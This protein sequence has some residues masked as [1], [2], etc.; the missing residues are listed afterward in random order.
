[1]ETLREQY[2][3]CLVL[4]GF[5][6]KKSLFIIILVYYLFFIFLFF[7]LEYYDGMPCQVDDDCGNYLG[8]CYDGACVLPSLEEVENQF[9]ECYIGAMSSSL[10]FYLK[11]VIFTLFSWLLCPCSLNNNS[12]PPPLQ[13]KI[14]GGMF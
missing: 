1:M 7:I 4:V 3:S 14:I 13:K 2:I 12:P 11:F 6:G 9:L 5:G 8:E 10:E